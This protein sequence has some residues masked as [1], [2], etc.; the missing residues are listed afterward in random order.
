[1]IISISK[2][3]SSNVNSKKVLINSCYIMFF[4]NI[5]LILTMLIFSKYISINLL[6]NKKTY[7]PLIACSLTLPFISIGYIIKGYF[8]GKQNMTPHMISNIIEQLFRLIII[9]LIINKIKRYDSTITITIYILLNILTESISIT[10]F[11][12]FLPK[13]KIIKKEDLKIDYQETKEILSISIP[14]ITGRLIGNLAFFL[15]PIILTKLLTNNNMS[16]SYISQEYAIYTTYVIN[17]L[18]IPSFIINAISNSLLPE[19]SNHYSKKNYKLLK[20]RIT[21]S[22]TLSLIIGITCSIIIYFLASPLLKL[23]YNTN[24]G[25]NYLKLITPFFFLYYL[26]SPLTSILTGINKI[27]KVTLISTSGIMLKLFL[28]TILCLLNL[29]IHSLIISEI[30]NIIYVTTSNLI[31]LKKELS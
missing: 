12:F 20:K 8:Y 9:S 14:S 2:R 7:Y 10:I 25:I 13:N 11:L 3:I 22:L 24:K 16:I 1:M 6:E 19:I 17:T 27:K 4:L 18:L 23:L 30:I 21:E 5:I 26:E 28:T 29:G 15:E 31:T